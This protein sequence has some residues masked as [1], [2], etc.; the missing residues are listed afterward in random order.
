MDSKQVSS[1]ISSVLPDLD[2][3]LIE[4]V[5][6]IILEKV[7]KIR[8]ARDIF[9]N[10][11]ELL[12]EYGVVEGPKQALTASSTIAE[13]LGIGNPQVDKKSSQPSTQ[14]QG[15]TQGKR[16]DKKEEK[17]KHSKAELKGKKNSKRK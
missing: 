5:T 7:S 15:E 8:T 14:G 2:V 10:I 17:K 16:K 9:D 3:P 13:K 12:I 6:A 1:V 4:Y 11:G